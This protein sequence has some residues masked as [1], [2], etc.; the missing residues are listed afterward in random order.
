MVTAGESITVSF[1]VSHQAQSRVGAIISR[2]SQ[3]SLRLNQAGGFSYTP[4]SNYNGEDSFSY[5]V[6]GGQG[7]QQWAL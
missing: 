6:S 1:L 7:A 2:V 4:T 5:R 3:G